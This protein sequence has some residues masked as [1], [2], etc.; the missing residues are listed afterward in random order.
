MSQRQHPL[1]MSSRRISLNFKKIFFYFYLL[2]FYFLI[3]GQ[4]LF[5]T[6]SFRRRCSK[7]QRIYDVGFT[8]KYQC[9]S[10]NFVFLKSFSCIRAEKRI[11][12]LVFFTN[13]EQLP[14]SW[15]LIRQGCGFITFS[16][17]VNKRRGCNIYMLQWYVETIL[18]FF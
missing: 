16:V 3:F 4:N 9:C 11:F 14:I 7:K 10:N 18:N 5:T 6:L 15:R 8:I 17:T 1:K 12:D 2:I 13:Q